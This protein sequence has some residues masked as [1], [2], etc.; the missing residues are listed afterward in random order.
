MSNRRRAKAEDAFVYFIECGRGGPIKVGRAVDPEFRLAELQ[1]GNP[2][3]LILLAHVSG[4]E[5]LERRL[6][7]EL[8]EFRIRGEWFKRTPQVAAV[9]RRELNRPGATSKTMSRHARS[10]A[11]CHTP[12]VRES[13]RLCDACLEFEEI[14]RQAAEGI[15]PFADLSAE[16]V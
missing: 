1:C 6:H 5:A 2:E 14:R 12:D 15:D 16:G 13:Q 9:I 11:N 4:G 8:A 3:E 10:C 7:R